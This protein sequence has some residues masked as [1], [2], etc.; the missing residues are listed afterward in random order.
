MG[1]KIK[2]EFLGKLQQAHH[3]LENIKDV[4][5]QLGYYN[6]NNN[7]PNWVDKVDTNVKLATISSAYNVRKNNQPNGSAINFNA[8]L[9]QVS[10]SVSNIADLDKYSKTLQTKVTDNI[11]KAL[12]NQGVM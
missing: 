1:D 8:P 11:V 10:G 12:K 7:L 2:D 4:N 3:I 5:E 6:T 9:I